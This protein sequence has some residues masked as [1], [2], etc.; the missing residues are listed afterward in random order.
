VLSLKPRHS[1]VFQALVVFI[2]FV[3]CIGSINILINY[4]LGKKSIEKNTLAV[5]TGLISTVEPSAQIATFLNDK[6]LANEIVRGLLSNDL[7]AKVLL[8]DSSGNELSS[9]IKIFQSKSL[10]VKRELYSPFETGEVVGSISIELNHE[11]IDALNQRYLLSLLMP[12]AL[13]TVLVST[14]IALFIWVYIK[15]KV[16]HFLED[17]NNL[18]LEQGEILPLKERKSEVDSLR[19]YINKLI[20]QMYN[21]LQAER[22]LRHKSEIQQRKFQAIYDNARSGIAL[23]DR[24][25]TIL[26]LNNACAYICQVIDA[27]T[28]AEDN[29]IDLFASHDFEVQSEI[30]AC[31]QDS[32][33]LHL[34]IFYPSNFIDGGT[35]L[36][37]SLTPIDEVSVLT[38]VNDITA[39]KQESLDAKLQA[40]TDPLTQL[41]N[42]LGFDQ[43][44]KKRIAKTGQGMQ[45]LT[46]MSIDLDQF[47]QVNDRFGHDM[48]DQVLLHVTH[49]LKEVTR[50]SDY[51]ARIGGDEFNILL[52]NMEQSLSAKIARRI[53]D[54][55]QTPIKFPDQI[56]VCIGASIGVVFV[57]QGVW[58]HTDTLLKRADQTMYKIKNNGKNNFAIV[59]YSSTA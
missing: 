20:E 3:V 5:T 9:D 36:Q 29:I 31:L 54:S 52:D 49:Q 12:L 47:K 16:E 1:L 41:G 8:L 38:I 25:G 44:F 39:L 40:R 34:E 2:L 10:A 21:L 19:D 58:A 32:T 14:I 26:S 51:C 50:Q 57:P 55:L 4:S 23:S 6:N 15:P 11:V 46:L 45:S 13:Q 33:R 24:D 27:D 42:R 18:N 56:E 43:E 48:G 28:D 37:I 17:I 35:W 22:S 7:V 59:D 53:V 30:L